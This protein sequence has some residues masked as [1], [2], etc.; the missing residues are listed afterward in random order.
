MSA[1]SWSWQWL[2]ILALG[3]CAWVSA[4]PPSLPGT[5]PLSMSGDIASELVAG[6]DRF[7]M[8]ELDQSVQRRAAH[9]KRDFSSAAA[10]DRSVEPNRQ[11][12]RHIIGLRNSRVPFAGPQVIAIAGR[13]P[14]LARGG[15]RCVLGSLAGNRRRQRR[16]FAALT[17]GAA[18]YRRCHRDPRCRPHPGADCRIGRRRGRR[19]AVCEAAGGSRVPRAGANTHRPYHRPAPAAG[20]DQR[21][22]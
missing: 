22:R 6:V 14:I 16:R 19:I 11:R 3:L 2:M 12:L 9:W 13:N 1:R 4:D 20:S 10:Y 8:R 18:A 15:V 5:D 17:D 21:R 7:L